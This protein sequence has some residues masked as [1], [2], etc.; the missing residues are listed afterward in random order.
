M[1]VQNME[2]AVQMEV[3]PRL[4]PSRFVSI[5]SQHAN[6]VPQ[7]TLLWSNINGHLEKSDIMKLGGVG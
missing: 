1:S 2:G 5:I 7:Q 4:L 6:A 3:E